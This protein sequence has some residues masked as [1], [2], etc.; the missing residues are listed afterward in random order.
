MSL[1][2]NQAE[3]HYRGHKHARRLKAIEAVKS[4]PKAVDSSSSSHK[5]KA[6]DLEAMLHLSGDPL[7]NTGQWWLLANSHC[8]TWEEE[9]ATQTPP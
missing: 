5:D 9:I 4:K 8:L 7:S 2:Q 1:Y 3:A 6:T